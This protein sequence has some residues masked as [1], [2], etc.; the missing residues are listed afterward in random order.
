[1]SV[2]IYK[3]NLKAYYPAFRLTDSDAVFDY[4]RLYS[5]RYSV[6]TS[7][8]LPPALAQRFL[9]FF[10]YNYDDYLISIS[11]CYK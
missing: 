9:L 10:V 6:E 7:I 8:N 5:K 11:N 3:I 1:M 2:L 4:F